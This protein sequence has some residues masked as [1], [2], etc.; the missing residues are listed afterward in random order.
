MQRINEKFYKTSML[1]KKKL[2][3]TG[4]EENFFIYVTNI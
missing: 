3:K 4:I 1:K 2:Q